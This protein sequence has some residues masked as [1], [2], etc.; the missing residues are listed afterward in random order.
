M[1]RKAYSTD[2]TDQAWSILE[3]LVPAATPGGRPA[4]WAR[5]EIVHAAFSLVRS[6]GAW[7]L[8]PHAFPPWQTVYHYVRQ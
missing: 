6:G 8:F 3:P 7:R 4:T 1:Q 5:R 2:L